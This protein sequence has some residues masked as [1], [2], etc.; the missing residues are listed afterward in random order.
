MANNYYSVIIIYMKKLKIISIILIV[1]IISFSLF[2]CDKDETTYLCYSDSNNFEFETI[3][4]SHYTV[5]LPKANYKYG[6]MFYLGTAITPDYYAY[7]AE[8]LARQGYV[9]A[10]PKSLLASIGYDKTETYTNEILAAYPNVYFFIGGHSQGGGAAVRRAVEQHNDSRV[11]DFSGI[12]LMSPMCSDTSDGGRVLT[13]GEGN[14]INKY[15][16]P[17]STKTLLLEAS[18]DNVLTDAMK[19]ISLT[20]MPSSYEHHII[21]PG[22]HMSFSTMDSDDVLKTF[23]NDG[24]GITQEQKESQRLQTVEYILAFLKSVVC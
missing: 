13:D 18:N 7:L 16:L 24:N 4:T 5:Y 11:R 9:V 14:T 23:L 6:L 2:A 22:A 10:F 21:T 19:A 8:P 3:T 1:V 15:K 17:D 12:I 20:A